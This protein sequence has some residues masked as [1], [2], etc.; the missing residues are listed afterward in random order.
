MSRIYTSR[1]ALGIQANT[2]S[3]LVFGWHIL[4]VQLPNLSR[5]PWMSRD[6]CQQ[7]KFQK[8]ECQHFQPPKTLKTYFVFGCHMYCTCYFDPLGIAKYLLLS[9][10][11]VF[12]QILRLSQPSTCSELEVD[13]SIDWMIFFGVGAGPKTLGTKWVKKFY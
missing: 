11:F 12:F 2:S 3:G 4:G 13:R 8:K 1:V 6:I 10:F 9:M 5:W 7:S